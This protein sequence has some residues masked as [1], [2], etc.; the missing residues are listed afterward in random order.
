MIARYASAVSSGTFVT[1]AL[2]YVMQLLISLQPG[3]E[4]D[5]PHRMPVRFTDMIIKD[6]PVQPRETI[7]PKEVLVDVRVTPQRPKYAAA[8]ETIGVSPGPPT[9]PTSGVIT[10]NPISDGP[11]VNLVRVS[12]QYPS[13]AIARELE[14]WVIVQFDV[15]A[16]GRV[17]NAAAVQSSNS[18]FERSAVKAAESFRFK[19]RVVNGVALASE[20]I[21]NLFSYELDKK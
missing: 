19:A 14:G 11:L 9:P 3:A 12:P 1:F 6:T 21:Q 18:V 2:L 17:I 10:F 5:R 15:T 8:Q 13:T 7:I 16:E 4:T 20:G